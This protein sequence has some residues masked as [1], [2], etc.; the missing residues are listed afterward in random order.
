MQRIQIQ[1]ALNAQIKA[2]LDLYLQEA[3]SKLFPHRLEFYTN[4]I[5]ITENLVKLNA[6]KKEKGITSY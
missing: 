2:V 5:S 4:Q 3:T 6:R 1:N